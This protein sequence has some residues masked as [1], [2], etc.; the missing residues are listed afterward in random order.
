MYISL[1][2]TKWKNHVGASD[3]GG[4]EF[5][6]NPSKIIELTVRGTGSKFYL[7]D[8][9][10]SRIDKPSYVECDES[11]ATIKAAHDIAVS[12]TITLPVYI[13]ND[14]TAATENIVVPTD[15]LV[16]ATRYNGSPLDTSWVMLEENSFKVQ[17]KKT[18]VAL[19]AEAILSLGST[20]LDYD[21]NPYTT[22]TIGS[23]EW[24]VENYRVTH[25]ADGTD[26]ALIDDPG[27]WQA[28][29]T[30]AYVYYNNDE[31][32][33]GHLG[34]LYN[35]YAL[36]NIHGF[37][38]LERN[39]VQEVGWRVSTLADWSALI[40]ALG[41]DITT[42][43]GHL[44]ETGTVHWLAPNVGA[45]DTYGFKWISGG[46]RFIDNPAGHGFSMQGVYGD[47]W[48]STPFDADEGYSVYASNDDAWLTYPYTC[49]FYCGLNVRLVR[50]V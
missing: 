30:G 20:L 41:G 26:I 29:T 12:K 7:G 36:G 22:V 31:A 2:I 32:N 21:G 17:A 44:K 5:I 47:L 39:G 46:N 11:V 9:S 24:I 1:N 3:I 19:S 35:F 27:L 14:P 49:L 50:D 38:Y 45:T 6:V 16:Y 40:L 10:L 18:L 34:C 48:T 28:D 8:Y 42:M 4:R 13:N 33:Y 25:Y 43:G 37:P 15:S 23:Q